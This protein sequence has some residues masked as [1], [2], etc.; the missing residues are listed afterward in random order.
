VLAVVLAREPPGGAVDTA[1]H[2]AAFDAAFWW[3]I[4]FGVLAVL[5]A[6]WLP[7][8]APRPAGSGEATRRTPS[9]R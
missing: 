8:A 1:A 6:R 7:A 5:P 9:L 2:A 4:A 3:A